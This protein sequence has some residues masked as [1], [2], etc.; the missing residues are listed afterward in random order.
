MTEFRRPDVDELKALWSRLSRQHLSGGQGCGCSF[1]GLVLQAS[2]FELDIVE[3]LLHDAAQHG[4][5]H[6]AAFVAAA[7]SR[8]PDRYSLPALLEALATTQDAAM[9]GSGDLDFAISRLRQ[10]LKNIDSAHRT[11]RFV[12][13]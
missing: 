6:I 12:C 5:V 3:F 11:R 13:D 10:T 9:I 2:D 8:G 1:G 7:A 4:A